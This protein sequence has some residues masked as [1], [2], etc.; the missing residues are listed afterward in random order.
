[1]HSTINIVVLHKV[2]RNSTPY[3]PLSLSLDTG[4]GPPGMGPPG[5][6]P[7]GFRGGPP[8]GR[9]MPPMGMGPPPGMRGRNYHVNNR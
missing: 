6:G 1:M 5:M 8:M 7:P 2:L 3:P 4:M 9:G